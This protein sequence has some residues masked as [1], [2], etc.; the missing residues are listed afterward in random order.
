MRVRIP[1]TLNQSEIG[2]LVMKK[3]V[4]LLLAVIF[5]CSIFVLNVQSAQALEDDLSDLSVEQ[6]IERV[7]QSQKVIN[8][9]TDLLSELF[10]DPDLEVIVSNNGQGILEFEEDPNEIPRLPVY[11]C[12]LPR[13]P[14]VNC[15]SLPRH[16]GVT[17]KDAHL[18]CK[19]AQ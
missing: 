15:E 8:L 10:V 5:V 14:E 3:I 11:T 1:P 2:I 18:K 16:I 9:E 17:C 7:R 13:K 12:V 6:L 19:Y 4:F